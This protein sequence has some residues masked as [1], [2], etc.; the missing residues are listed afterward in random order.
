[1]IFDTTI[2][3]DLLR[4]LIREKNVFVKIGEGKWPYGIERGLLGIQE[5]GERTVLMPG[6][7]LRPATEQKLGSQEN[8]IASFLKRQDIPENELVIVEIIAR[9]INFAEQ[10]H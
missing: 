7:W 10:P 2:G 5:G 8:L 1:M 4:G 6:A 9:R 3:S